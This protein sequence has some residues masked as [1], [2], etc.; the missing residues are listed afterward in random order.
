MVMAAEMK[1]NE[2]EGL[3]APG[4]RFLRILNFM[5]GEMGDGEEVKKDRE[6]ARGFWSCP[7]RTRPGEGAWNYRRGGGLFAS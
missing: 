5:R 6:G 1:A 7:G 3:S 4:L 2:P